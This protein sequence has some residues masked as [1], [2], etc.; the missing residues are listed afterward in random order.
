MPSGPPAEEARACG[1][2]LRVT[3]GYTPGESPVETLVRATTTGPVRTDL[4]RALHRTAC[5]ACAAASYAASA[6]RSAAAADI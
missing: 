3:T 2:V 5:M 6:T 4:L 1:G